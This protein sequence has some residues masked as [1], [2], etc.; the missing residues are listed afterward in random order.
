[1]KPMK[2]GL[3]LDGK[4]E[5]TIIPW[6]ITRPAPPRRTRIPLNDPSSGSQIK[7]RVRVGDRVRVGEKLA[8][9][10]AVSGVAVHSSISGK[11]NEIAAFPHPLGGE[12]ESI[13]VFSDGK[14]ERL[15][16]IGRERPSWDSLAP[17]EVA[18]ILQDLGV[19]AIAPL[20]ESGTDVV[21]LNGCE[22]EP[23]LTRE[24]CLMMSHPMEIL[25]GGEILRRAVGAKNLIVAVADDKEE[26][27]ELLKSKI[28]LHSRPSVRVEI[29]PSRYPQGNPKLL[30]R[31]FSSEGR[32]AVFDVASAYAAYEAVAL[33][34][35]LY[36]RPVT[37]GGECV[38]Q[39]RNFWIRTGT[40][41]E[42]AV[43][44]ARG[45]LRPPEKVILGGP[46][47]GQAVAT[48]D[49]PILKE[50]S[51]ILGL[52]H[53]VVR[54]EAA[55]PCI[56]CGRCLESCPVSISPAMVTLAAERD[57]FDLAEEF[58]ARLCIECGN[59]SYVCPSN[60]PMLELIQYAN[61]H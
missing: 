61:A 42:E 20:L 18:G 32:A 31:D 19:L 48:L 45:F 3:Q 57:L 52:P 50:T 51:G 53:E 6:T 25:K 13:E 10:D 55:E 27:A 37:I 17:R 5:A 11:V 12:R 46:M 8:E 59:C 24:H 35:P 49:V 41:V 16:E 22:S 7:V 34:K 54:P 40:L 14:D 47:T 43:K 4:K 1:M 39:P 29:L 60:R 28:F 21:I 30:I 38:A 23:Y 44:Y 15:S 58:G 33:Q 26:V 9:A 2:G 36:E 56:R